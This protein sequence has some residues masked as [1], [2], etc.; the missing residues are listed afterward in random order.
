M[1]CSPGGG[2]EGGREG[3][4]EGGVEI[5]EIRCVDC[6]NEGEGAKQILTPDPPLL[7]PSLPHLEPLADEEA[8]SR[9][10]QVDPGEAAGEVLGEGEG[11]GGREGGRDVGREGGY[12]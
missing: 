10:D 11:E 7:P 12:E 6:R 9:I 3:G 5:V 1:S 8:F 4:K 2:G